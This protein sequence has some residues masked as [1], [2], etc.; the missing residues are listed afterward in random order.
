MGGRCHLFLYE[1]DSYCG[2][3]GTEPQCDSQHRSIPRL[4][5][6]SEAA[7]VLSVPGHQAPRIS[8]LWG[9]GFSVSGPGGTRGF[10]RRKEPV[11]GH[12]H[13]MVLSSVVLTCPA[14]SK[15]YWP[16]TPQVRD[17]PSGVVTMCGPKT[18]RFLWDLALGLPLG[19]ESQQESD[20]SECGDTSV[21]RPSL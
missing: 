14:R 11:P 3:V 5:A 4:R 12:Q 18:P 9:P 20:E 19:Q 21:L 6:G 8:D 16:L 2:L 1:S 13:V 10:C 17:G 7:Q 15:P